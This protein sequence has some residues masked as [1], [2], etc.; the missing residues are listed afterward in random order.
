MTVAWTER[1]LRTLAAIAEAFVPGDDAQRRAGL[2]AG[3]LERAADPV[4]VGQFRLV[5][6]AMETRAVN[7][8]L[9]AGPTPFSAMTQ[10]AR[11]RYLMRWAAS[12]V[13]QRRTVFAT[14]RKL[15]TFLAYGDPEGAAGAGTVNPRHAAIGYAPDRPPITTDPTPIVPTALPFA[16][17]LAHEPMTLEADVV[18]VGAGAGG[19]VVA[20]EL[21]SAGRSVVV[22]EAGPFVDER[23]MPTDELDAY[24]RLYLNHGL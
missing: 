16:A 20:A 14:L 23:T 11:E 7:L 1:E 6:R 18:I 13:P 19:G 9:G 10:P 8:A 4:Q 21:A 15:S 22:L 5:L 17:G 12:S 24:S 3:A 2:I